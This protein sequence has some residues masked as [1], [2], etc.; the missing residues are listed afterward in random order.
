MLAAE[1][2]LLQQLGLPYRVVLI[3][4]GDLGNSAA[5]KFDCEAW[6]PGQQKYR[7]MTSTSNCTDFQSRR[8]GIKMKRQDGRREF[9]H[10][11]NG[12]AV[13]TRPVIAMLENFQQPDG[14]V[15]L[16][17]VLWPFM[18]GVQVLRADGG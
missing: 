6:L 18:G 12:T 16:P 2:D 4:A 17:K 11:L 9:A 7:E 10:T 15:Q 8:L 13:S 5:K 14:S 3:A 1:E